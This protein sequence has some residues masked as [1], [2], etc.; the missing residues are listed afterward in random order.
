MSFSIKERCKYFIRSALNIGQEKICPFCGSKSYLLIDKKYFVTSLLRC[1]DCC[2]Q[3]RFPRDSEAFL[4][5]S[6][7]H[8]GIRSLEFT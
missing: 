3:Y 8:S 5:K 1:N 7:Q 2:L 6:F 4:K